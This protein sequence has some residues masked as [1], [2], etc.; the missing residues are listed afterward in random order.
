[1]VPGESTLGLGLPAGWE[2]S[3]PYME[4]RGAAGQRGAGLNAPCR[5][6]A[7]AHKCKPARAAT[8]D[9]SPCPSRPP[10]CRGTVCDDGFNDAAAA[11]ACRQLGL[12]GGRAVP[13]AKLGAGT[14]SIWVDE[15]ACSGTEAR[16]QDC[17]RAA[18]GE[19]DCSHD[20]DV[21]VMCLGEAGMDGGDT[22]F[23]S[24][25]V[26]GLLRCTVR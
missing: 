12:Y 9:E 8:I 5:P 4:A 6:T 21:G 3:G 14:G 24:A 10:A 25:A 16:L 22:G 2:A 7:H 11:V 23:R 19:N 18:W 17:Q 20:E 13:R 1:M 26:S 15:I